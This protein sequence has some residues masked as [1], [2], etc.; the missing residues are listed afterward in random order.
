M[1]VDTIFQALQEGFARA[2]KSLWVQG[3]PEFAA[4]LRLG[5]VLKGK[6]LRHFEGGRYLVSFGGQ[7]K[8]VDSGVPL[9][10][11]EVLYGRVMA[12]DDKVHLQRV[13]ATHD[14]AGGA[15]ESSPGAGQTPGKAPAGTVVMIS[16]G[17]ASVTTAGTPPKSRTSSA[18][19]DEK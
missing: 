11:G 16:A 2:G 1:N 8:V 13:S 10:T 7:E 12:L 4:T 3:D 18:G 9:R 17:V 14:G 15:S 19:T 5:Q 6:V